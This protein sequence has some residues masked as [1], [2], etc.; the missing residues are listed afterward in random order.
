MSDKNFLAKIIGRLVARGVTAQDAEAVA[1]EIQADA[2][3][4]I[5]INTTDSGSAASG[6]MTDALSNFEKRVQ[7][8]IEPLTTKINAIETRDA[9]RTKDEAEEEERKKKETKDAEEAEA[10]AKKK[11][12]EEEGKTTGDMV[13]E[14]ETVGHVINLGKVYTGDA[15][16]LVQI[17]ARAEILSPGIQVPTADSLKPNKDGTQMRDH[18]RRVL[19]ESLKGKNA[20]SVQTFLAGR[21][22]DSLSG[23]NLVT[24]Y[25][26]AA[27][28]ARLSNTASTTS[29]AGISR[30]MRTGDT[31]NKRKTAAEINEV[32]R[33]YREDVSKRSQIHG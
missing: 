8:M 19:T 18:M 32:N 9:Q 10:L 22:V 17:N 26:G 20:K 2:P 5:V 7:A 15:A 24:A 13:L 25:N 33:K 29:A 3:A 11:K 27:E 12:E 14:A 23:M 6:N 21:T 16:P 1:R 28:L 31:G 30:Q 4:P